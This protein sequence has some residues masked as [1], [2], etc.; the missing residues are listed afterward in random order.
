MK[1]MALGR[2][3]AQ[4]ARRADPKPVLTLCMTQPRSVFYVFKG[5]EMDLPAWAHRP[6][7]C[8]SEIARASAD[9]RPRDNT[10]PMIAKCAESRQ[11]RARIASSIA[12]SALPALAPFGPPACAMSGRPPPPLPPRGG[13]PSR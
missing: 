5:F 8:L 1:L 7:D 10:H 3:P 2:A 12:A 6:L 11:A 4:N 9:G 13:A